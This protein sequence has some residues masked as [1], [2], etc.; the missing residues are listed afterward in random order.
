MFVRADMVKHQGRVRGA[1]NVTRKK[2]PPDAQY[3]K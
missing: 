1:K 3:D 2:D